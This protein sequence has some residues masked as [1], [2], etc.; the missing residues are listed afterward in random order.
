[1]K[2]IGGGERGGKILKLWRREK[3][4]GGENIKIVGEGIKNL[5]RENNKN[6]EEGIKK[7]EEGKMLK[8]KKMR[9]ENSKIVEEEENKNE[10][11]RGK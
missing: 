9:K 3:N 10:R 2:T 6:V 7:I 1:M 4:W 8:T 5:R 11:E